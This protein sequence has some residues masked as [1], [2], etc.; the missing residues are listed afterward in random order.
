MMS[1]GWDI[2][3]LLYLEQEVDDNKTG[4][5]SENGNTDKKP[6]IIEN[7][8]AVADNN[9]KKK[10]DSVAEQKRGSVSAVQTGDETDITQYLVILTTAIICIALIRKKQRKHDL[11]R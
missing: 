6:E 2:R 3:D 8:D 7:G 4:N 10:N 5:E 9:V 11:R 1:Q